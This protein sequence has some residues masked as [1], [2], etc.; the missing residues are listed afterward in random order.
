MGTLYSAITS[1]MRSLDEN[2]P[3]LLS[4]VNPAINDNY[5]VGGSYSRGFSGIADPG[6]M[7]TPASNEFTCGSWVKTAGPFAHS[8][9]WAAIAN[10]TGTDNWEEVAYL[11]WKTNDQVLEL[12]TDSAGPSWVGGASFGLRAS[13]DLSSTQLQ[14][15]MNWMHV[16]VYVHFQAAFVVS[17]YLD[18]IQILT[19]TSGGG[20]WLTGPDA[21]TIMK[22]DSSG[23]DATYV[24][25]SF[26]EDVNGEG[27]QIPKNY[28]FVMA[29]PDG[30]GSSSQWTPDSGTNY[31][32]VNESTAPD[33]DTSYVETATA[34]QLDLY[35]FAD[36]TEGPSTELP[37]WS[38]TEYGV[39]MQSFYRIVD[40]G[41]AT[42]A[43]Y[44]H[45][46][47]DGA[48][49][50]TDGPFTDA[51]DFDWHFAESFFP[52]QPDGSAWNLTDFNAWEYGLETN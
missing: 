50:L 15:M 27:D 11:L 46:V 38:Y 20:E 51:D 4:G 16:G 47:F 8:F 34:A 48:L 42:E 52:L 31:A 44:D 43:S 5:A 41:E 26:V 36:L 9:L 17:C 23:V 24:D 40:D 7:P 45:Y 33:D 14:R 19:Y 3:R 39:L 29:L 25:D 22:G 10:E 32:R 30:A 28:S 37:Y 6:S 35:T 21:V 18:G 1:E 13:V 12:W 49:S 2:L